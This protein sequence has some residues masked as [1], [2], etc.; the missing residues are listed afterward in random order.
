MF[1]CEALAPPLC[2]AARQPI[3]GFGPEGLF[4][5]QCTTGNNSALLPMDI[6][7]KPGQTESVQEA[8][9]L[10]NAGVQNWCSTGEGKS[11]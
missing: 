1:R 10:A 11:N 5:G 8:N 2:S 3:P 7:K 4:S 9:G 6:H